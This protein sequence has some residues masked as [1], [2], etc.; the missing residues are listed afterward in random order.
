MSENTGSAKAAGASRNSQDLRVQ[1]AA[2]RYTLDPDLGVL[3]CG[4]EVGFDPIRNAELVRRANIAPLLA[5]A[6]QKIVRY[7][8][9]DPPED[10]SSYSQD[11]WAAREAL[12][13]WE[14]QS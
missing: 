13:Q 3:D 9:D 14:A 11:G 2:V 4:N 1:T 7:W 12:A 5:E 6:L 8:D 10:E